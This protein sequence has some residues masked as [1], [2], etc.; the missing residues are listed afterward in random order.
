[1]TIVKY[2][3]DYGSAYSYLASTQLPQQDFQVD[4]LPITAVDVMALVSNQPT[5]K[6]PAKVAYAVRDTIRLAQHYSVPF[7]LNEQWWSALQSNAI[8]MR[9]YSCGAL[10]AQQLGHFQAYHR[11]MLDA[12]WGHPRD[13]VSEEGRM[14]L[15]QDLGVPAKDVWD[16]AR[17]KEFESKLDQRNAEAATAGVFGVPIFVVDEEMYFGSDRLDLVIQHAA[18]SSR[19]KAFT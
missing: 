6:C 4:Y 12:I 16:L 19:S 7:K 13:V 17:T 1:M 14:A 2:Y 10:A 18:A 15:L 3:F 11:A 8:S 5:A 9:L